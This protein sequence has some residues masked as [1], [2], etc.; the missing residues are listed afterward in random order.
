MSGSMSDSMSDRVCQNL[1]HIE[2]V[3]LYARYRVPGTM[4]DRVSEPMPGSV[5]IYVRCQLRCQNLCLVE[6]QNLCQ[7]VS[8]SMPGR[9][10]HVRI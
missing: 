5:T 2:N 10:C 4:L 1:C 9:E 3:R 7:V 8:E 6:C